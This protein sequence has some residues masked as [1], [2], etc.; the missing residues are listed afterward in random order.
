MIFSF[1]FSQIPYKLGLRIL[2]DTLQL[3]PYYLHFAYSVLFLHVNFN[4]CLFL[5]SQIYLCVVILFPVGSGFWDMNGFP[6]SSC[7]LPGFHFVHLDFIWKLSWC[8]VWGVDPII[9]F[10]TLFSHY[11]LRHLPFSYWLECPL[12]VW[13]YLWTVYLFVCINAPGGHSSNTETLL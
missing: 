13:V 5:R 6:L 1:Q 9:Y 3:F 10:P 8:E 4:Y 11:L 2:H 12:S 7:F